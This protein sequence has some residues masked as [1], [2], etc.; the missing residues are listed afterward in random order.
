[1]EIQQNN[2]LGTEKISRL[3]LK[4]AVPSIIAMLVSALYNIVDQIFV[5]NSVGMLGNAA[6]NVAF[7]L[8]TL[9]I[10]TALLFGIGGATNFNLSLGAKKYQSAQK[11]VGNA[12]GLLLAF[13]I[14]LGA[15]VFIFVTPLIRLCGATEE[16][17][18]L[19]HTYTRICAIGFP[20]LVFSTGFSA[21]IRADGS[22][23]F[24]M[25]SM[26]AGAIL[27]TI[28]DPIFIFA[29]DMGIAGAAWATVIGQIA[30]AL[31]AGFYMFRMKHIR[32][33]RKAF[34]PSLRMDL[35]LCALGT[36]NC[37]TQ[38]AMMTVQ[39]V[40]NNVLTFHG[41]NSPYGSEIPLTAAGIIAKVS[42]IILAVI[43]GISQGLQ[44]IISFNYG[45]KQYHRVRQAYLLAILSGTAI[46]I[47]ATLAFLI[48]P[49]QI[50][51]LFGTGSELYFVFAQQ[52]CRIYLFCTFINALQP[53]TSNFFT[54]IGKAS[55]GIFLSLTRQILFLL[56]LLI[57]LPMIFGVNG[58]M[59]SGPIAD[60]I[61]AGVTVTV[62]VPALHKIK[63]KE[64]EAKSLPPS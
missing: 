48:F 22:P 37:L 46:S 58:V 60:F 25:I 6:T 38:L 31:V 33:N 17:F 40:T 1:M 21:I 43:I 34:V 44:P 19:A 42:M 20:F 36:S 59:F 30:S 62:V 3:L 52:Y 61:A 7:P 11:F 63:K 54:A 49:R 12:I 35:R 26:L 2:P 41:A 13:G 28:L 4:F 51:S 29:C 32:L 53:I 47:L 39:I 8:S 45:A 5:G 55:I 24:S 15:C 23:K 10:A 18:S 64:L 9:C 56:P 16:V 14:L 50:L 27:N 57:F